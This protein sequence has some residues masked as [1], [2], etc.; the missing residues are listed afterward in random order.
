[1]NELYLLLIIGV[2]TSTLVAFGLLS[3]GGSTDIQSVTHNIK[4]GK[5]VY[6]IELARNNNQFFDIIVDPSTGKVAKLNEA[7]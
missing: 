7:L 2:S 3:H 4:Y 1:M 6:E 5:S